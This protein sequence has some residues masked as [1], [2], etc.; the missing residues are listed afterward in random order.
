MA[1]AEINKEKDEAKRSLEDAPL[2]TRKHIDAF[3][4]VNAPGY[5]K[6]ADLMARYNEVA[7][8]RRFRSLNIFT[9]MS[10]QAELVELESRLK[11]LFKE[12]QKENPIMLQDFWE[13]GNNSSELRELVATIK[14][15]LKEYNDTLLLVGQVS[16]LKNPHKA[17]LHFIHNWLKGLRPEEGQSFLRGAERFTWSED[18]DLDEFF[19][20]KA[21]ESEADA[22]TG[23]LVDW[24]ITT[25]N[26]FLGRRIQHNADSRLGVIEYS[27]LK[28]TAKFL[29]TLVSSMLP[30]LSILALYF[31]KKLLS[32]IG[33]MISMTFVFASALTFGTSARRIEIFSATA[34]FA[35]VEVV[36]I[37]STD[38]GNGTKPG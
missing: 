25:Y 3:Q 27:G 38:V 19:V 32:R 15:T 6:L 37:G 21:R 33:I 24:I 4:D 29:V 12:Y 2:G 31:E 23:R 16:S 8:F 35:A 18:F 26:H 20:V 5:P 36:F 10:L 14:R 9:L 1:E 30:A 28:T 11:E 13:I 17:D 34:A 22:A 7:I